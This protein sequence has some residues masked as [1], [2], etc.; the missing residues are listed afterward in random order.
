MNVGVGVAAA[1][2]LFKEG[3]HGVKL[4]KPLDQSIKKKLTGNSSDN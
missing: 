3:G 2:I 1:Y 4:L